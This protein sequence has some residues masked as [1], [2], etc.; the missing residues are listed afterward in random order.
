MA[1]PHSYGAQFIDGIR[2]APS[3]QSYR[4]GE[5]HE[6]MRAY[7]AHCGTRKVSADWAAFDRIAERVSIEAGRICDGMRD[8]FTVDYDHLLATEETIELDAQFQQP[9]L[10]RGL[11]AIYLDNPEIQFPQPIE[12]AYAGTLDVI[13]GLTETH[14]LIDDYKS[15]P[16][17]FEADTP[18][19]LMYP[20]LLFQKMPWLELVTFQL[21]FVRYRNC[22][23]SVT[24]KRAELP[25][26]MDEMQR[27]RNRQI[28]MHA[29]YD[30]GGLDALAA[31]PHAGCHYCPLLSMGECPV[32]NVNPNNQSPEDLTHELQFLEKRR[33][34]I[35]GF[36]KNVVQARGGPI[37]VTDDNGTELS[38]GVSASESKSYPAQECLPVIQEWCTATGDQAFAASINLSSTGLKSKLD[39][40]KRASLR[41]ELEPMLRT[42]TKTKTGLTARNIGDAPADEEFYG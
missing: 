42:V 1:C 29:T 12:T 9:S 18:Q 37:V 25:K 6:V 20:V 16:V 8:W 40:Q 3:E 13:Y 21:T 4:G 38:F 19:S 17:P 11:S 39:T 30:E 7:A 5:V 35:R 22:R 33:D 27:Y 31:I 14:A 23:R 24:W 15:H 32:A 34:F 2:S 41:H 28:G 26:M 10:P 36:L